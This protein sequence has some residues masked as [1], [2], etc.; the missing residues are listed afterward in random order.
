MHF[1]WK[2]L[3]PTQEE[4][5]EAKALGEKLNISNILSLLLVRRGIKT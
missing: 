3:P 4:T 1:K 5:S 2:Y